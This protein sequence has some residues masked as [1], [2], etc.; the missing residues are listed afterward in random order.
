MFSC[1]FDPEELPAPIEPRLLLPGHRYAPSATQ[2]EFK[3]EGRSFDHAD[4]IDDESSFCAAEDRFDSS[5]NDVEMPVPDASDDPPDVRYPSKDRNANNLVNAAS[6][7]TAF[8]E[9]IGTSQHLDEMPRMHTPLEETLAQQRE[10]QLM[11]EGL[12]R[13]SRADQPQTQKDSQHQQFIA[14]ACASESARDA[15]HAGQ[16]EIPTGLPVQQQR[17]QK[18]PV[19][20]GSYH[21]VP[22]FIRP[23][24]PNIQRSR[25]PV[26]APQR[27]SGPPPPLQ[28]SSSGQPP[29]ISGQQM[30]SSSG[31]N[32]SWTVK[33][34]S[35]R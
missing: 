3:N 23:S 25:L 15:V 30:E 22:R 33:G 1:D 21:P 31:R 27:R 12:L 34:E 20:A 28:Q 9:V 16:P 24:M 8:T 35:T 29:P 17:P 11:L 10:Q 7:R 19:Q 2:G 13:P 4:Q 14:T 32:A 26:L 6:Y 18:R 5:T